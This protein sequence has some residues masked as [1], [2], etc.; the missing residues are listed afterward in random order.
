MPT[1]EAALRNSTWGKTLT[2]EEFARALAGTCERTIE[3]GAFVCMK[4]EPVDHWMGVVDGLV[5]MTSNWVTGKT[6]TF[7]GLAAGGWF[8]EGSLLKKDVRKYDVMALRTSRIAYLNRNTFLWLMDHSIPFNRF[9]IT[10]LNERLGQFIGMME[11]ERLLDTDA[12]LAR[13]LAAMFNPVLY[14]GTGPELQISQEEIGFLA[15]LSRQRVNQALKALQE[16]NLLRLEYG[17]LTI[18]D[19]DGLRNYG[20]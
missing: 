2:E 6:T 18:L 12:R 14:P 3:T 19:L 10:Q 17:K 4:G 20:G 8:G 7:T 9:L 5:K 1:L 16:A 11:N 13:N 15:G